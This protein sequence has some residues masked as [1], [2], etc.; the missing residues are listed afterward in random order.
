MKKVN[1]SKLMHLKFK[2]KIV[3]NVYLTRCNAMQCVRIRCNNY[4]CIVL[5]EYAFLRK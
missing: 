4:N 5:H 1:V 2:E 3:D